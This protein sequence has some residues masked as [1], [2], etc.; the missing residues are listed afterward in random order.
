ME[1]TAQ[2]MKFICAIR[3]VLQTIEWSI[4]EISNVNDTNFMIYLMN[5]AS[6]TRSDRK[7]EK[8]I[9]VVFC[10]Y[11]VLLNFRTSVLIFIT[12]ITSRWKLDLLREGIESN[13]GSLWDK[14]IEELK[15]ELKSELFEKHCD[16]LL[17]FK[18][19]N[20]IETSTQFLEQI[21]KLEIKKEM[22]DEIR[23]IVSK[24]SP[25]KFA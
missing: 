7:Y 19:D 3:F 18:K 8:N 22:R 17:K 1:I 11:W 16:A 6:I 15:L 24:M 2:G 5:L 12:G 23:I 21:E 9:L 4:S 20:D 13:P 25:G 14:I 10:G